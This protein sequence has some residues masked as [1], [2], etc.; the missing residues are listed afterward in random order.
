MFVRLKQ[1]DLGLPV[2]ATSAFEIPKAGQGRKSC[3]TSAHVS[4]RGGMFAVVNFVGFEPDPHALR[5]VTFLV[6]S[7]V[8]LDTDLI[9]R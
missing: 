7:N 3:Q 5:F 4:S 8:K 1:V 9:Q 6:A 2:V